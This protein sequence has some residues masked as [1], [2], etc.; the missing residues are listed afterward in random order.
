MSLVPDLSQARFGREQQARSRHRN[1]AG[2]MVFA[3]SRGDEVSRENPGWKHGAF[4][5]AILDGLAGSADS[6]QNGQI[7]IRELQASV[8]AQVIEMT[9]DQQHP[10]LPKLGEFDPDLVIATTND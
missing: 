8:T 9:N 4:C 7:T 3:S 1:T 10:H 6:N 2:V 5:K